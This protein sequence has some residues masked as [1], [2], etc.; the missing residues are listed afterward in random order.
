MRMWHKT[1]TPYLCNQHLLGAHGELHKHR[2]SFIK[3]YRIKKRVFPI[4]QLEPNRM[5][6]YH[7]ELVTEMLKRGFNHHSPYHLP[8][9]TYLPAWQREAE[10]DLNENLIRLSQCPACAENLK[11]Y[12]ITYEE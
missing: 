12:G 3:H 9:L 10:I 7:A 5:E 11:T 8:D 4:V 1:L 6:V 2:P